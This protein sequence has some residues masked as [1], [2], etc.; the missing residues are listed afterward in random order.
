MTYRHRWRRQPVRAKRDTAGIAKVNIIPELEPEPE[1]LPAASKYSVVYMSGGL[2]SVVCNGQVI[3]T[4]LSNA[5]AWALVDRRDQDAG[6]M[7]DTRVRIGDAFS[8]R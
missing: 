6:R 1:P 8:K 2:C 3:S 5:D 7:E 4:G